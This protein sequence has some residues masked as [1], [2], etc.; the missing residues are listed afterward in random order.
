MPGRHDDGEVKTSET[1]PNFYQTT[2]SYNLEDSHLST[3]RSGN[4]KSYNNI[5]V[6]NPE[7]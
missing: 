3:H 7:Q 2:G 6:C 1:L 5:L 4:Y